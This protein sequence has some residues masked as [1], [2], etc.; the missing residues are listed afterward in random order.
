MYKY[1][2]DG[3]VKEFDRCIAQR[4][5]GTTYAVTEKKA[6]ANLS[7]QFKKEFGRAAS[8]KITLPGKLNRVG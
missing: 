7:Y 5:C 3:P 6:L 2:Y 8:A 1:S 4:W